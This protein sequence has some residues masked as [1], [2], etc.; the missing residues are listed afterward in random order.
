MAGIDDNEASVGHGGQS[1]SA[2]LWDDAIGSGGAV[3]GLLLTLTWPAIRG[4]LIRTP[5]RAMYA[6]SMSLKLLARRSGREAP[7][8]IVE[9]A[10]NLPRV[11][12]VA[13]R[14]DEVHLR[15]PLWSRG[16][17]MRNAASRHSR[18]CSRWLPPVSPLLLLYKRSHRLQRVT[19]EVPRSGSQYHRLIQSG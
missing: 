7:N 12:R 8:G 16:P 19:T 18:R 3:H 17:A 13:Y 4:N 10:E 14:Y 1:D 9:V 6:S 11:V 15:S 5:S 2:R